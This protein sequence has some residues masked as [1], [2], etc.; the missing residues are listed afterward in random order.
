MKNNITRADKRSQALKMRAAKY[1]YD[2]I[3][4]ALGFKN[5]SAAYKLVNKA[6][7][8][9]ESEDV[10]LLRMEEG[11]MLDVLHQ[12]LWAQLYD[13]N[14]KLNLRVIDRLLAISDRRCKLWGL[15]RKAGDND[16]VY[17]SKVIIREV[18]AG[19][20]QSV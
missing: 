18:P 4:R 17:Y 9:Y 3:A 7:E 13:K 8:E 1:T 2:E 19:Y 14:G 5:R 20:I 6:L 16:S 12:K 11:Y 15:Y 10:R